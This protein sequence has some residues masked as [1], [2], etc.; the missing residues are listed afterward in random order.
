MCRLA[1]LYSGEQGVRKNPTLAR[2]WEL[3][4]ARK[5]DSTGAYNLGI[6]YRNEGQ[7]ERALAWI[8]KALEMGDAAANFDIGMLHL[9]MSS[10]EKAIPYLK[11]FLKL[12]PP[13]GATDEDWLDTHWILRKLRVIHLDAR[14]WRYDERDRLFDRADK[15]WKKGNFKTAI[16]LYRESAKRG[17]W[18]AQW[19]MGHFYARGDGVRQSSAK[20]RYWFRRE[21]RMVPDP[22][23]A[24]AIAKSYLGDGRVARAVAWFNRAE[25]FLEI[26]KI[27]LDRGNRTDALRNLRKVL[28]AKPSNRASTADRKEAQDLLERIS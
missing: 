17:Q 13:C 27:D 24:H 15:H 16:R 8:K 3:R 1:N 9:Q 23:A 6:G 7:L 20:A 5:G 18:M 4:A 12:K 22:N 14:Y 25:A 19:Y 26:A 21:Y 11:A 28:E 2:S 10:P